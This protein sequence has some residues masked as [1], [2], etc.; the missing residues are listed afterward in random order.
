MPR[1]R[2]HRS[3]DDGHDRARPRPSRSRRRARLSRVHAAL[4]AP[5]LGRARRRGDLARHARASCGRRAASARVRGARR[6][7]ARHHQ[8]ARD[9]GALGSA[10]RPAGPPRDRLAGPA[11]RRALRRA[12]RGRAS[13]SWC[14]G[15][16]ASSS[17]PTSPARSSRWLLEQRARRRPS[18]RARG[19]LCFGTID[20]WLVWKLTGGAVH[21][22]DP[23]NASRTLL[24]DIHARA[25]DPELCRL[26]DVPDGGAAG[27]AAVERHLRRD[28]DGRARAPGADRRASPAISRRRSSA[29]AASSPAWRRTPTAPA[30]SSC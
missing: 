26:L 12:A 16:P 4:P 18:G 1:R 24:Y 30:A 29:R 2:R 27:G 3:G 17:I 11:H 5:G 10:H 28:H 13:R 22:T 15:R 14:G 8:P 20:S 21:A 6:R 7:R 23:T 9:D 19:E 25:W